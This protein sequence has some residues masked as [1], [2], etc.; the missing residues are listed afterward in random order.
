M[1]GTAG[2]PSMGLLSPRGHLGLST[3]GLIPG[4]QTS[5]MVAGFQE[6]RAPK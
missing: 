3:A 5:Y 4:R 1:A 6:E 2:P